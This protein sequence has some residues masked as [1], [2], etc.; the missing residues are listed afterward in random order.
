MKTPKI[1]YHYTD[2]KG[3]MGIIG[4]QSLRFSELSNANDL[5]ERCSESN[6]RYIS[7]TTDGNT[8]G[9]ENPMMWAH[10]A[11]MYKGICIGFFFDKLRE[12]NSWIADVGFFIEYKSLDFMRNECPADEK[13]LRFKMLEWEHERE[14]R[15]L[16]DTERHMPISH[17]CIASIHV[18]KESFTDEEIKWMLRVGVN[19]KIFGIYFKNGIADTFSLEQSPSTQLHRVVWLKNVPYEVAI[20][21]E[22]V[23]TSEA[24]RNA[25][26]YHAAL[27]GKEEA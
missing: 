6:H 24:I 5:H 23:T 13:G 12:L 22:D 4:S 7:F 18:H 2:L 25:R 20:C 9:C 21:K 19:R 8:K 10:Y 26:K 1:L 16:S 17:D 14:Y 27:A 11:K 15:L 3:F